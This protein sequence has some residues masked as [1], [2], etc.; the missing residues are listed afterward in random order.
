MLMTVLKGKLAIK[1]S[2]TLVMTFKAMKDYISENKFLLDRRENF[3]ANKVLEN[4]EKIRKIDAKVN[5]IADEITDVIK[6]SEVL[7]MRRFF[8]R[9]RR[10]NYLYSQ[11][12]RRLYQE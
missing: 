1:Q 3:I 2:R 10:Q 4:D 11:N 7:P 9:F 8:Q 5:K 6:K 12:Q